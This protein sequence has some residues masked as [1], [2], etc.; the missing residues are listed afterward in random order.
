MT[1]Q[2]VLDWLEER[3]ASEHDLAGM[4]RY[5]FVRRAGSR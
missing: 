5:G 3:R 2:E 4:A 1:V